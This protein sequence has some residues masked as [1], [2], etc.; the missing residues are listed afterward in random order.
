[1]PFSRISGRCFTTAHHIKQININ[2]VVIIQNYNPSGGAVPQNWRHELRRERFQILCRNSVDPYTARS[3]M[4]RDA[5]YAALAIDE[6]DKVLGFALG[7]PVAPHVWY[8]SVLCTSHGT[9][10]LGRR[11]WDTF[12]E[13]VGGLGARSV[14]IDAIDSARGFWLGMGFVDNRG[15]PSY[16]EGNHSVYPMVY[17]MRRRR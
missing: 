5:Q 7:Q 16:T 2:M 4:M 17:S 6:D 12:L 15:K 8:L 3:N 11:L 10:G 14:Q 13:D 9:T 1:M